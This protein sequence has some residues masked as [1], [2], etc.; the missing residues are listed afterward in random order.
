[1][2]SISSLEE[3]NTLFAEYIRS[4]NTTLHTGINCTPF[5]RYQASVKNVQFPKSREWLDECF[6][7]RIIRKVRKDATVSFGK[8]SYDVPMQFIDMK[9]EIRFRPGEM[10]SAFILFEK[11]HYPIRPTNKVENCHTKRNNGP[12]IDY[13]KLGDSNV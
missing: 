6:L 3:F 13:S 5:E 9:V 1:M 4:Y 11:E 7:N 8:V 12:T 10:D 2:D